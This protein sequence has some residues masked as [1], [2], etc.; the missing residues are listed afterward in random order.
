[1]SG[2][3][4]PQAL[5]VSVVIPAYRVTAYV[6]QA[7]DSVLAQT[8][9]DFEILVVNDACPDTEALEIALAPYLTKIRYLKHAR[10]AGPSAARNT[11]I[12]EARGEFVAFLDGDDLYEPEYLA[13]QIE[14]FRE[15]PEADM[16]YGSALIFGDDPCEGSPIEDFCPSNEP[17]STSSLLRGTV[18]VLL[19][20][21]IRRDMLVRAG[22]FDESIRKC[23]DFDLWLRITKLGGRILH[24]D[25]P[26]ARYRVRGDSASADA[27]EMFGFLMLVGEKLER[28]W[29]LTSDEAKALA[30]ARLRWTAEC[31]LELAKRAFRDGRL[32][33]AAERFR[34]AN[35][36]L[37][38]PKLSAAE[39][40]LRWTPGLVALARECHKV[41][42]TNGRTMKSEQR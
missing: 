26:I 15:H 12:R 9:R 8:F 1:M 29:K 17:V 27:V 35:Q 19:M 11:G 10:N 41:F 18:T 16:I 14:Q 30:D 23:E 24:H 6:G 31:D 28:E 32:Q 22:L 4:L 21:V 2:Q 40:A 5:A 34:S 20:S 33:E 42:A 13:V 38:R 25:R 37:K 36:F 39:L 3:A 7:I